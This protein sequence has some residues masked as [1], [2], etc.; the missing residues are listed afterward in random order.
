MQRK[1][2][3]ATARLLPYLLFALSVVSLDAQSTGDSRLSYDVTQ[4]ITLGGTVSDVLV[5]PASGMITGPHLLLATVS[6][7]VDTSLGRWALQGK[8]ALKLSI[9]QPVEV[10]GVMKT[11]RDR[12]VLLA[13]TVKVGGKIYVMRN[14]HGI[15]V[16]P[17][18]RERASRAAHKED[19]L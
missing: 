3:W 1:C 14:R 12:R 15:P 4:E 11:V 17:Q 6:G 13:R 19:L 5:K 18:A 8:D 9:G 10:T 7:A 2:T 16:P